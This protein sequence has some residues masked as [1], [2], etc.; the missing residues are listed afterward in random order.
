MRIWPAIIAEN[1]A[2]TEHKEAGELLANERLLFVCASKAYFK[3]GETSDPQHWMEAALLAQQHRNALEKLNAAM[4]A[5]HF[6]I[7]GRQPRLDEIDRG[8]EALRD[9]LQGGK[10]LTKWSEL[11]TSRKKKWLDYARCVLNAALKS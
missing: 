3:A 11:P 6:G 1:T 10:R 8:A 7:H 4:V 2:M 9:R 5:D